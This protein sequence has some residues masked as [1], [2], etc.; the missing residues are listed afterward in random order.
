MGQGDAGGGERGLQP[1]CRGAAASAGEERG[2]EAA[3]SW[4][5]SPTLLRALEVVELGKE[6]VAGYIIPITAKNF[7]PCLA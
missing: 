6:I 3:R 1:V 4:D 2:A 7:S 5:V